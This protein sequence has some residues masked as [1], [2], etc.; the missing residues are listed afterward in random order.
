MESRTMKR[1]SWLSGK[2][3]VP[4]E[5]TGFSVAMQMKGRGTGRV[6]PSTVTAR[7]SMTSSSADWVFA[8][9][10]LIS[11]PSKRLQFT[12]PHMKRNSPESRSYMVKPVMSEGVVSGVN[13]TRLYSSP[14]ARQCERERRL[15]GAG[16]VFEEDVPA[17]VD[18]HEG[19][20]D[21]LALS[22]ERAP[23]FG[24][25]GFRLF[26]D[27]GWSLLYADSAAAAASWDFSSVISMGFPAC[28]F[29]PAS[30]DARASS[31]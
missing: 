17:G 21:D 19:L 18:R 5:P 6:V 11:S 7:S 28:P 10:R 20:L 1:S 4:A 2:G 29:M 13:W 23:H 9:V 30:R 15:A 8:L 27:Q 16:R 24:D 12:A 31:T 26:D 25:D 3:C 22:D 14:S